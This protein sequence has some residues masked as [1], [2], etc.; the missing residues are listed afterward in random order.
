MY[1][2]GKGLTDM[3]L[4]NERGINEQSVKQDGNYLF[5]AA[6]PMFAHRTCGVGY[7]ANDLTNETYQYFAV[8][9]MRFAKVCDENGK[10]VADKTRI[11]YNDHITIENIPFNAINILLMAN[12]PLSE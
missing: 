4:K 6:M 9:K 7:L 1:E 11:I 3:H 10:L 5:F 8:N 2:T 12:P